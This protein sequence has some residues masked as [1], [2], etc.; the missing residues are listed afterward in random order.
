MG[1]KWVDGKWVD[2][3][4]VGGRLNGR[5]GEWMDEIIGG[6]MI[7]H[8]SIKMHCINI[9]DVHTKVDADSIWQL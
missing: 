8:A 3:K 4:L 5:M 9:V 7:S 6:I 2:G 1:G